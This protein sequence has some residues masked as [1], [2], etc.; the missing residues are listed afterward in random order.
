MNIPIRW[1]RLADILNHMPKLEDIPPL[2]DPDV[3]TTFVLDAH[4][5][6]SVNVDD[7]MPTYTVDTMFTSVDDLLGDTEGDDDDAENAN[8]V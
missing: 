7:I 4:C 8:D 6:I 5:T 3:E 2:S 1:D